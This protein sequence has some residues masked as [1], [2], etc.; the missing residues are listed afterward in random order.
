VLLLLLLLLL[1]GDASRGN[2]GT[3][4]MQLRPLAAR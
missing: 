2:E 3:M 4:L 1:R